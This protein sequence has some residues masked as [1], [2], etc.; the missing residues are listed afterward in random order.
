MHYKNKIV[1]FANNFNQTHKTMPVKPI[2]DGYHTITPYLLVENLTG[3]LDF[4]V[5]AFGAKNVK[6]TKM[7]DGVITHADVQIG[8][9]HLMIGK[10][11]EDWKPNATMIYLYVPD[12]D[13]TYQQALSAGATSLMEP[14]DQHYGDRNAGVLDFSGNQWW[15]ATH[16]EDVSPEEMQKREEARYAAQK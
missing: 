15:I 1:Y 9:S 13:A 3:Y 8:D 14:A 10:A 12:T 2:P 7:P 4:L 11:N 6:A 5:K 16:V